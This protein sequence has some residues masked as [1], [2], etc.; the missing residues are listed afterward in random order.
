MRFLRCRAASAAGSDRGQPVRTGSERGP[1]GEQGERGEKGDAGA[2]GE[3]GEKGDPGLPGKDAP[4]GAVIVSAP[5][6]LPWL[7]EEGPAAGAAKGSQH[8]PQH[9]APDDKAPA[10]EEGLP[11][12]YYFLTGLS[13]LV[14]A[15]SPLLLAFFEK[16]KKDGD[17]NTELADKLPPIV[18][19]CIQLLVLVLG[20][21][22][23]TYLVL[24]FVQW[25]LV[26]ICVYTL[27]VPLA[28]VCYSYG[29]KLLADTQHRSR[30]ADLKFRD[31]ERRRF[32]QDS[33][34]SGL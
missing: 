31:K 9:G 22:F 6:M 27:V 5:I 26:F 1:Q 3:R 8:G 32:E 7:F 16:K 19:T 29:L 18:Y 25:L 2:R 34:Q 4:Q 23:V 12:F 30:L 17:R 21:W 28:F 14:T 10:K 11:H 24:H 20:G 15:L 33:S 13:G